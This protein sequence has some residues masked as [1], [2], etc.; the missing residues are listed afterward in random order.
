ML[1]FFLKNKAWVVLFRHLCH[2]SEMHKRFLT[3]LIALLI[4]KAAILVWVVL[5]S[6]IGLGPDEAQYWTWSRILDWGYYSK[7]PGI[8]WEIRLGTEVFGNTLL[9]VRF[10]ALLIGFMLP[11]AIY[12][13]ARSCRVV[14]AGCFWGAAAFALSPMGIMSSFL[15]ITDGG[16]VLFWVLAC[17]PLVLALLEEGRG[18]NYLIVGFLVACGALF[19]WPIYF[20]WLLI[21]VGWYWFPKLISRRIVSGIGVSLLGLLPSI[22]WNA[23]H[24]WGTFRH[25]LATMQGGHGKGVSVGGNI[26][27]FIGSQ[28]ALVSPILFFLL[29][30]AFL[31][32]KN[33]KTPGV[34]FCG[35]L[36]VAILGVALVASM[37]MKL[38]GNWAIFAYPASF[39]VLGAYVESQPL[40]KRW[41][42]AGIALSVLLCGMVFSIPYLQ[43]SHLAKIPYKWNP[44]KHNVGWDHLEEVLEQVH[45]DPKN[46][47]LFADKYQTASVLSFYGPEQKRAYFLNLHGIRHNQFS[48]WPGMAEEQLG[49]KGF[50]VLVENLPHL[51]KLT[52]EFIQELEKSLKPYFSKVQFLGI[53]PLYQV[54]GEMVKGA[55][56]IEGMDYNGKIPE[57]SVLY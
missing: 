26:L 10:G 31:K 36:S 54:D 28:I 50:F 33:V 18:P 23:T 38:Q 49:N 46:D 3:L 39:V 11:L 27:E 37:F 12:G 30:L 53:F 24:E 21:G 48:Y 22:Y 41:L 19:K 4:L 32:L 6:G 57:E 56:V 55:L 47:F 42:K 15:A 13:L 7:P 1:K 40:L 20:L 43:S 2:G 25:V 45:Y 17:I 35:Y 52:P 5:Q 29:L 16:M 14:P 44:F 8:A 51:R 34:L 9:G